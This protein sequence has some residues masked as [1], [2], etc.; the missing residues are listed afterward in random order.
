LARNKIFGVVIAL[1]V[2]TAGI[3]AGWQRAGDREV[4]PAYNP[5]NL[6]RLHVVA[7]SDTLADQVLK[8][9]VRDVVINAMAARFEGVQ[10]V[11]LARELVRENLAGLVSVAG[12]E[13]TACGYDY[14]VVVT[15]G[16]YEFP[17]KTYYP[18]QPGTGKPLTLPPGEYEALRVV[19]GAGKG[20]NWWC[21]LFPPLCFTSIKQAA[22]EP[23]LADAGPAKVELRLRVVDFWHELKSNN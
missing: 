6:I 14:P 12:Q 18:T 5:D 2:F 10:D 4:L 20:A 22:A 8:N 16:Q 19:I 9:R 11:E 21:V 13:I 7:N 3:A 15:T 17:S 23:S 1:A